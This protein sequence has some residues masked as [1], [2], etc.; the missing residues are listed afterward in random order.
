MSST[1]FRRITSLFA[2]PLGLVL[3]SGSAGALP[4]AGFVHSSSATVQSGAM[5]TPRIAP[6][7][8]GWVEG[9]DS[10][11]DAL[12][13]PG[14][15][16]LRQNPVASTL[17]ANLQG[18]LGYNLFI[19]NSTGQQFQPGVVYQ[20]SASMTLSVSGPITCDP[21]SDPTVTSAFLFDQ[22]QYAAGRISSFA[23]RFVCSG[24]VLGVDMRGALASGV[25]RSTPHQ[26]Y[27]AY[28]S[29]GFISP[30]G[31]DAF[32]SYLGDLSATPL[33]QPIVGMAQT[34]DGGG[35]WMVASDGGIFAFGDA[36]F[37]GS[38]GGTPLN[39][40]IV[41]MAATPD[42]G[43]YWMVASDGGIFAFGDAA[44]QGS[45]GGT[46]LNRPIVGMAAN[47][48][49]GYWLVASD[50]GIFAFGGALFFGSAGNLVLNKPVVG[51][52]ATTDG[53]GYWFVASDGGIFSY[54]DASF[55]GSTGAI[56]LNQPIVGMATVPSGAG[57]WLIA[58]D[59]GIFAFNAPYLGS[60]PGDGVAVDDV[61]GLSV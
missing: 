54:G 24:T 23:L 56:S 35:Y 46:P 60:I 59:G 43:G 4:L 32:L 22:V 50:G 40:P 10:L 34:S 45:M 48:S 49:G 61:V 44:F 7:S 6:L 39:R 14:Q 57:Y 41:G 13:T 53:H 12:Y 26:G 16:V 36:A 31:N 27:Y 30:Y 3:F 20:S 58:T 5:I 42:G 55:H 17:Q 28:E 18:N 21:T 38:M 15:V 52:T 47:P 1:V 19:T 2:I 8:S 11:G 25:V 29:T 51:M 33:N 37:Q 9:T